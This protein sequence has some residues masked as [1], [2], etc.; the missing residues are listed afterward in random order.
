MF[1]KRGFFTV[2][3]KS[4]ILMMK[5]TYH[6]TG[7]G[8]RPGVGLPKGSGEQNASGDTLEGSTF[9]SHCCN[10]VN[11]GNGGTILDNSDNG[12]G[13]STECGGVVVNHCDQQ[14]SLHRLYCEHND[15]TT[16]QNRRSFMVALSKLVDTA[17]ELDSKNEYYYR[18]LCI[19]GGNLDVPPYYCVNCQFKLFLGHCCEF[20]GKLASTDIKKLKVFF[21]AVKNFNDKMGPFMEDVRKSHKIF[22]DKLPKQW[23]FPYSLVNNTAPFTK[24]GK[25]IKTLDKKC[26]EEM[27]NGNSESKQPLEPCKMGKSSADIINK[28]FPDKEEESIIWTS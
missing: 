27:V 3:N 6:D 28:I 5:N 13:N 16:D 11:N 25:L 4:D 26:H 17:I 10:F 23:T 19:L 12:R 8:E 9:G 1:Y 20:L 21:E 7:G 14:V 24:L 15:S 18:C 22:V 2:I